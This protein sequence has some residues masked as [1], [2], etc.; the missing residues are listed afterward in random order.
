MDRNKISEQASTLLGKM[1]TDAESSQQSG[2]AWLSKRKS[3]KAVRHKAVVRRLE[4]TLDADDPRLKKAK[5]KAERTTETAAAFKQ[6]T[7]RLKRKPRLGEKD[8]MVSGTLRNKN[9]RA[10]A[11]LIVQVYDKDFKFVDLLG[12]TQT[13]TFGDFHMVY[14]TCRFEDEWGSEQP[15]LFLQVMSKEGKVLKAPKE[16]LNVKSGSISYVSLVVSPA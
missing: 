10:A 15:D 11:G 2:Y 12:K 9:G 16:P 3:K 7:T 14:D 1:L 13:D 4:E 6:R 5:I 8:W